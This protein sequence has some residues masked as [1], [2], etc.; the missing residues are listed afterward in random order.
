MIGYDY[1]V[2]KG[3]TWRDNQGGLF[4]MSPPYA[5]LNH[6]KHNI[7]LLL[8]SC[9]AAFIRWE[10]DFDIESPTAWWHV[11]KRHPDSIDS[12]SKKTRYYIRKASKS[13]SAMPVSRDK[14]LLNGYDVYVSAYKRY[15]T[16]EKLLE[17]SQFKLAIKKLP[18]NTEFWGVYEIKS[19]KLVAFSENYIEA[20]TCFYVTIW[21]EPDAMKKFTGYLLFHEMELHYLRDRGFKYISDGA[22]SLSHNTNI[23]DFLESKFN[24]RKAYARLHVVY[25]PWL[26]LAVATAYP[27]RYLIKKLPLTIFQKVFILLKQEEIRRECARR[28]N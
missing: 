12:L 20:K 25:T 19:S 22:R 27:F 16:H 6:Y 7:T 21:L 5:I 11:I 26:G 17:K 4:L 8:K 3:V 14:V 2:R 28:T 18:T 24:F 23:H 13:Y 1:I 9:S 10:S 15:S